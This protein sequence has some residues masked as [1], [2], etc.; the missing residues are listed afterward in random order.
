MLERIVLELSKRLKQVKTLSNKK[1][2]KITRRDEQGIYVETESSRT[3]YLRG[4]KD[5]SF[6]FISHKFIIEGWY[7]FINASKAEANDFKKTRGRSSF[8]MALFSSLPFVEVSNTGRTNK[9]Y[10]KEFKTDELPN[11]Q[12]QNVKLFL[13]EVIKGTYDPKH[14]KEH[15]NGNEYRVKSRSRQDARLLGFIDEFN[16]INTPL[17]DTYT[18]AANKDQLIKGILLNLGYFRVSLI[19]LDLLRDY[20]KKEKKLAVEELGMLIVR[21]S[22]GDNLM[23]ESVAKERTHNLFMWLESTGLI[24]AEGNPTESFFET[25]DKKEQLMTSN[26]RNSL[27][28]V[29]EEY[30]G[31]KRESLGGHLLGSF[32]R[33]DIPQR[34]YQLSFIDSAEYVVTGSVGQGNWASVPWIAIMNRKIT[35]STQ[36][37]YYIVYLF[38]EDME[39]VYLTLAQGVTETSKE[40]MLRIKE[41]I[42]DSILESSKVRIDHDIHLGT[43]TKARQYAMSTAAYISY[44][45]DN[46]PSEDVL[47]ADLKEMINIYENFISLKNGYEMIT[48]TPPVVKDKETVYLTYKDLIDHIYAYIESKG[49]Y[50][51]KEEVINLF[52]SLK[53]KPFVILSGIS[54]TGKTKMVQ[55]FAESVGANEENGQFALIPIRPDWNDGSDLLGYVDI[56]G[57]FKKGPLTKVIERA[58][59][60]PTLPYFVLLDE[61]NL[62]RVEYY[63]SDILSVME[64]RKWKD[65]EMVSSNLLSRETAGIDLKLPNNLYIIGT[66]NMDETT[67]PFSKKVLDRANTIEFNRVDLGNLDFLK[68]Q[69][70]VESI[71]IGH[72]RLSSKYLHL[73]DVYQSH[74]ALVERTTEELV[75]I[76]KSL[77]LINAQVGYRVRD[78]ICFYLAYNEEGSLLDDDEAMDHCIL[79]KILPRIAGSDSRVDQL[80]R[81]LYQQFT[82]KLYEEDQDSYEAD[83][84]TARYRNSATKVL[85]MLRRLRDDGFTSFWIS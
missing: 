52:L 48:P 1:E 43:S 14:L 54:G 46:M 78:E 47:V 6:E 26:I 83:L 13:D 49:F 66:V 30:L 37:G 41:E 73:K 22:R 7:D 76:N 20:P 70:E 51:E 57:E 62:A 38:S 17:L 64:S 18:Q 31:A 85:E 42:R 16:E 50:Y 4:E 60:N 53:T 58:K 72:E 63:F 2:N 81:Q 23:V 40:D 11:D 55:W 69:E 8:L 24:D 21:N 3:K 67:H 36:R 12:Y 33:N 77:E 75:K 39:S 10:L 61:M 82:G 59:E 27:L 79:Q 19:C 32:V 34:F 45:A 65:G 5:N 84:K 71:S 80:L 68:E 25:L 56:K 29:M 9:I 15:F 28:K 44:A 35:I 74:Q